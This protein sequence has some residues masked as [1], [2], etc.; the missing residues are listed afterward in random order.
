ME[1]EC[2]SLSTAAHSLICLHGLLF[3]LD[4]IHGLG[5][6]DKISTI[7]TAFEDNMPALTLAT[8]DSPQTPHSESLAI[9][10]CQFHSKSSLPMVLVKH[11]GTNNDV[12]DIFAKALPFKIF[13]QHQKMLHS[14]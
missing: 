8:T 3:E 5:L 9:K 11:D 14:W 4:R 13:S 6:G 1:S 7:S 2:I 10:C 12:A